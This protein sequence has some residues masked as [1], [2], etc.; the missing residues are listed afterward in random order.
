MR[1]L[2]V[3]DVMLG[4]VV[5]E[6]LRHKPPEY[7]WGDTLPLFQRADLRICNLECAISDRGAPWVATPKAFHFRSDARNIA[8]LRAARTGGAPTTHAER[9]PSARRLHAFAQPSSVIPE[10]PKLCPRVSWR[11]QES[12]S[13]P[14][15]AITEALAGS[16]AG[17]SAHR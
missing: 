3:G 10:Y 9:T 11:A 16:A 8:V 5:N 4:R 2:F 13:R 12:A 15:G 14:H 17:C 6:T 7:P 1:L